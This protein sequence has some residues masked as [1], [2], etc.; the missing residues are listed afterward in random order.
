MILALFFILFLFR[1][2]YFM[3]ALCCSHRIGYSNQG[4]ERSILYA[5][6]VATKSEFGR[7][8]KVRIRVCKPKRGRQLFVVLNLYEYCADEDVSVKYGERARATTYCF[9]RFFVL[10]GHGELNFGNSPRAVNWVEGKLR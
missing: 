1:I 5:L 3:L 7:E 9:V 8:K 2:V 6:S 4:F 10:A